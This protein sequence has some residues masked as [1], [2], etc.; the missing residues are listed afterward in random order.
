MSGP[1]SVPPPAKRSAN[2]RAQEIQFRRELAE[3]LAE[4]SDRLPEHPVTRQ[5]A[6]RIQDPGRQDEGKR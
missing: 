4:S 3:F 2:V 5:Q 6:E 1:R